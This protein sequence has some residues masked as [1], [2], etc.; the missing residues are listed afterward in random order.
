MGLYR[1][2]G[3]ITRLGQCEFTNDYE[4]Y[5]Y[6]EIATSSGGRQMIKK[7]AV[8]ADIA[9]CLFQG[10]EGD[11][12]FDDVFVP[13][14]R[15]HCQLWGI[16]SAERAVIDGVNLRVSM[17]RLNLLCGVLFTPVFGAG[18]LRLVAGIGQMMSMLNGSADRLKFFEGT[19]EQLGSPGQNLAGQPGKR[20]LVAD[21]SQ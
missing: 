4:I 14:R 11:F 13:G 10:L 2:S 18:T 20:R 3:T 9:A 19:L 8:F 16:R 21:A 6:V 12:Y 7:V 5:A 15:A 1:F 17:M